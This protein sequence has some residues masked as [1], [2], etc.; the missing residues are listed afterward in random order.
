MTTSIS[1]AKTIYTI[2]E[3]C[4]FYCPIFYLHSN[5]IYKPY[6]LP[7]LIRSCKFEYDGIL[8]NPPTP[9]DIITQLIT[10]K[11]MYV[12][13]NTVLNTADTTEKLLSLLGR[14]T[15][16]S[17]T[18][19]PERR[20]LIVDLEKKS[21][22]PEVQAIFSDPFIYMKKT[23]F[24]ITYLLFYA[25]NGTLEPHKF[26]QE[27]ATFLFTCKSY[28]FK[29]NDT[30]E[31]YIPTLERIYL[32][33]H[34][35]GKWFN[36][37]EFEF[38]DE[39]PYI[40]IALESHSMYNEPMIVRR[41]F[42]FGNDETSK[43]DVYDPI[44][45][46]IVLAH[47]SSILIKTYYSLNKLYYFNGKYEDQFSIIFS[48]RRTNILQY[49]G[50]YK[51]ANT[52]ELWNI[53]PFKDIRGFIVTVLYIIAVFMFFILLDNNDFYILI[54]YICLIISTIIGVFLFQWLYLS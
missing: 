2:D 34:G 4:K 52:A 25:Y 6:S 3:I 54:S 44:T 47:P 49:D 30:L 32:S 26:D 15:G 38:L 10:P 36:R 28:Q 22:T 43:G 5:E 17:E 13:E 31:I 42:G 9:P 27:Y 50:Y 23:Y 12:I 35:K 19:S 20:L 53:K 16:L 18:H 21:T 7:D 37:D 51:A 46:V 33:S 40:Y 41:F 48:E 11:P 8:P 24:T 1:P 45:N 14:F 29:N 39:R